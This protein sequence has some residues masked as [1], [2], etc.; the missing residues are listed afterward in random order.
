[1]ACFQRDQLVPQVEVQSSSSLSL[2]VPEHWDD[3]TSC[4]KLIDVPADTEEWR[5]YEGKFTYSLPVTVKRII[6]IQNLWLWEAYQ[7]KK[8]R[9]QC[10]NKGIV[11]ELTLF[12][13]SKENDPMV[14]CKGEDGFDL[15]LSNKGTW[16][17]ALYFAESTKYAGRFAH[18]NSE[19]DKELM[20]VLVLT[21]E[22]YDCKIIVHTVLICNYIGWVSSICFIKH[23]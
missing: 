9:I 23:V 5:F 13:G 2:N 1:M 22:A 17:V 14:I 19:G 20:V 12:H 6:R 18:T 15:K 3:Q 4:V 10:K 11:N 16:G 7:F 8:Y 21:G